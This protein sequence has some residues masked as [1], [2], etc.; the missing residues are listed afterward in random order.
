MIAVL[1]V[2]PG[3][4]Q[5]DQ[6]LEEDAKPVKKV[7]TS[8]VFQESP[9]DDVVARTIWNLIYNYIINDVKA[10][11]TFYLL[12]FKFFVSSVHKICIFSR[13]NLVETI[14]KRIRDFL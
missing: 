6:D 7:K 11:K 2:G 14:G 9:C 3:R 4:E 8:E 10:A 5:Q 1:R 13:A 12:A